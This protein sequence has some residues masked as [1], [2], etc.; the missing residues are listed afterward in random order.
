VEDLRRAADDPRSPADGGGRAW[1]ETADGSPPRAA[2]GQ[3]GTWT[4]VYEAGPLGVAEGGTVRLTV[5]GFW[6]WSKAQA[7]APQSPGYTDVG[8]D[9]DGV[10]LEVRSPNDYNWLDAVVQ[11]RALAEGEQVRFVYGAGPRQARADR[12]AESGSR[13]WISVD[14]DGDGVTSILADSPHLRVEPGPP[15]RL[16]LTWPSTA[17]PGDRVILRATILDQLGNYGCRFVGELIL[18]SGTEAVPLPETTAFTEDN[19]GVRAIEVEVGEAGVYRIVGYALA[20]GEPEDEEPRLVAMSNPLLVAEHNARILWADLQGHSNV[21]DG[22]GTPEEYH[23]YARDVAGLDVVALTDHDHWGM[24]FLDRHPELWEEN[25]DV[26]K[27]Y[28][29]PGTFVALLGYEWTSWIH[30]HRHV[31]YFTDEGEVLSS[32]DPAYETPTQLWE[33]LRG[34]EAMT[35]AHH[36]AGDPIPVNWE[37]VPDPELEPVTEIASVHGSSE[38]PDSPRP[39][40]HPLEGNFV[41]DVIDRGYRLGF[42]GSGDSHDGHSGFADIAS[43]NGTG[44]A[45]LLTED[46]TRDGVREALLQRRC[47]ATNGPRIVLRTALGAHRM[48]AAV[49]ASDLGDKAVLYVRALPQMPLAYVDVVRRDL[50]SRTEFD[51]ETWSFE[52]TIELGSLRKGDYVYVRVVQV[53]GGAAWSSPI[54]IE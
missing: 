26:V 9:A 15:A 48:G 46:L 1:I 3:A 24:L 11:S 29:D 4:I 28:H 19:R 43:G 34:R 52:A 17:H 47:Y 32:I 22:T 23:R 30:G 2:V 7:E 50:V 10:V 51:E 31:L 6:G 14:G 45:A 38:A 41:R 37:F 8:T 39:I 16:R 27:R 53:D 35:I 13:F 36:S 44:L 49:S 54:F 18:E 5:P 33:G 25:K 40:R 12:F 21:S 42:I 20:E